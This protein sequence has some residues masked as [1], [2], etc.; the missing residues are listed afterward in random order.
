[1]IDWNDYF[2]YDETSPT[3]LRRVRDIWSGKDYRILSVRK[4]E[5]AGYKDGHYWTIVL[6]KKKYVLHRIIW[7]IHNGVIPEGM[8]IDHIDGDKYNNKIENLRVVSRFGNARNVRMNIKNKSGVTGVSLHEDVRRN[9]SVDAWVANWK[10]LDNKLVTKSFS[11]NKYGYDEAFRLACEWREKMILALNAQG[12]G[13]TER[14]G[15]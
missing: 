7:E 13:Y 12:A 9:P 8:F 15:K 6:H 10:N 5:I 1:M 14:H 4:D 2:Y 3:C 11:I